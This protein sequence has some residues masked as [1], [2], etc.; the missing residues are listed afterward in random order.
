MPRHGDQQ[1]PSTRLL[2]IMYLNMRVADLDCVFLSGLKDKNID[3][4]QNASTF[5]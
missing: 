5:L 3:I 1:I 2:N 4:L